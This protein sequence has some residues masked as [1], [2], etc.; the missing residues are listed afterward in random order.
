MLNKYS[1]IFY[2]Q[3]RHTVPFNN[4]VLYCVYCIVY[5]YNIYTT[6]VIVV[7]EI[8]IVNTNSYLL[9]LYLVSVL[10]KARTIDLCN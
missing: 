7:L 3:I 6:L 9:Q 8:M 10:I 4:T 2:D 1:S 5:E